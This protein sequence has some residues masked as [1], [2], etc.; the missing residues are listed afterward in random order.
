MRG[1]ISQNM[2]QL[3]PIPERLDSCGYSTVTN[4]KNIFFFFREIQLKK[5]KFRK[6]YYLLH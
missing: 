1:G 6:K 5:K 2:S 4:L 3:V